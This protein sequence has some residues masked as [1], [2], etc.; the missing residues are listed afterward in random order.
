[1]NNDTNQTI[2][3][4]S[5]IT[6]PIGVNTN[7][8]YKGNELM[9]L[10]LPPV[11]YLVEDLI[12]DGSFTL[13]AGEEGCGKSL[14][15]LNMGISVACDLDSF[16]GHR[17]SKSGKVLFLNNELSFVDHVERFKKN[18]SILSPSD[19]AKLDNFIC[20]DTFPSFP[21]Y[22]KELEAKIIESKP[23]LVIL[24]C[25][26][27]AHNKKE[28]DS[29]E[30][31]ALMRIFDHLRKKYNVAFIVVHHTKKGSKNDIMHNDNIR[32]SGVF[33]GVA[34]QVIQIRRSSRNEALRLF[35]C[36]K[37]RHGSDNLRK[38][39][40]ISLDSQTLWFKDMGEVDEEEHLPRIEMQNQNSGRLVQ[41]KTIYGN[42][43]KLSRGQILANCYSIGL[44]FDKR[45]I[46]RH[47][48]K[49][50]ETGELVKED[51]GN[52]SLPIDNIEE[53]VT[54]V[55]VPFAPLVDEGLSNSA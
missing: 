27:W 29:T 30:M 2:G 11:P 41:F 6:N 28:N 36:T 34:D 47:I 4:E 48:K 9:S 7:T 44:P 54:T 53:K 52:Y 8:Y 33:A 12:R 3:T 18:V 37:T 19:V 51:Y 35:K 24:D 39:H 23:K 43:L 42:E 16:L 10:N 46:D 49:A 22:S 15:A 50:V 14:I 31:K 25:L 45:T 17:I 32:G 20:P 40:L 5:S 38:A 13:L 1:M 55:T 26:Y 21:E